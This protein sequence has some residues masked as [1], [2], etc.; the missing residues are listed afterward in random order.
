MYFGGKIAS[1]SGSYA[2]GEEGR[3][4]LVQRALKLRYELRVS[5][6]RAACELRCELRVSCV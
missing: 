1:N 5:C 3:G 4:G 2:N 6:V